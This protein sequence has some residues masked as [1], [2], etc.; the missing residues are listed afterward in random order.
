LRAAN[1]Q[2]TRQTFLSNA[3]MQSNERPG[4]QINH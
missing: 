3:G 4:S 2:N 1:Q